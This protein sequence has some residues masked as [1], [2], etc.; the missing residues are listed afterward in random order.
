MAAGNIIRRITKVIREEHRIAASRQPSAPTSAPETPFFGPTTPGLNAPASHY[1]SYD[2]TTM[3][4]PALNRQA[5]LSN[6]VAM[7]H[8]R[9]QL[10]RQGS[11]VDTSLN[12][13]PGSN[14]LFAAAVDRKGSSD[15]LVATPPAMTPREEVDDST[16]S[17]NLRPFISQVVEEVLEELEST[18]DDVAKDAKEHIHSSYVHSRC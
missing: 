17:K 11:V 7:R 15:S 8:S 3:S 13:S 18:H 2:F 1:L 5:S 14:A 9:A 4:T 6:F 10:E 16:R 12:L